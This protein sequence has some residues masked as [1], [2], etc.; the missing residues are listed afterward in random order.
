MS[1]SAQRLNRLLA[2]LAALV[3][4]VGAVL[5]ASRVHTAVMSQDPYMHYLPQARAL[6]N[7]EWS[8]LALRNLFRER[9]PGIPLLLAT[10]IELRDTSWIAW[11]NL[12]FFLLWLG[13]LT[14]L[15]HRWLIDI[16]R[17]TATA[18]L[19]LPALG[20]IGGT[21]AVTTLLLRDNPLAA[22]FLLTPFREM[23]TLAFA[24]TALAL[25]LAPRRL[26]W[27]HALL[28][29]GCLLAATGCREVALAAAPGCLFAC[30]FRGCHPLANPFNESAT[31]WQSHH[32]G[33]QTRFRRTAGVVTAFLFPFVFAIGVLVTLGGLRGLNPQVSGT[34]DKLF[35]PGGGPPGYDLATLLLSQ[36]MWV[37]APLGFLSLW[38]VVRRPALL[39]W[40]G[41]P[42]ALTFLVYRV[43]PG[44]ERYAMAVLAWAL[45]LPVFGALALLGRWKRQWPIAGFAV[46]ALAAF[47]W[48]AAN[49]R[50]WGLKVSS[51]DVTAFREAFETHVPANGPVYYERGTRL[52]SAMVESY[53]HAGHTASPRPDEPVHLLSPLNQAATDAPDLSEHSGMR[54]AQVLL[55]KRDLNPVD[56][57]PLRL[58]DA[59]YQLS[60]ATPWRANAGQQ[61]L[62]KQPHGNGESYILLDARLAEGSGKRTVSM[63]GFG[64]NDWR[65]TW[66]ETGLGLL[67]LPPNAAHQTGHLRWND[68]NAPVPGALLIGR[69]RGDKPIAWGLG[70]TRFG[71]VMQ[72]FDDAWIRGASA[73]K[74]SLRLQPGVPATIVLPPMLNNTPKHWYA[75]FKFRNTKSDPSARLV[76]RTVQTETHPETILSDEPLLTTP[77]INLH[78]N[79]PGPMP[80]LDFRQEGGKGLLLMAMYQHIHPGPQKPGI[81]LPAPSNQD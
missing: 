56:T 38:A 67:Y 6:V 17:A 27:W 44:H 23:P 16:P 70:N 45:P 71:S 18:R 12:P 76:V 11:I 48:T 77:E 54:M 24:F 47:L 69:V 58:G 8:G 79:G 63:S 78:L 2:I 5:A 53:T 75:S 64:T 40:L 26:R 51:A 59:T 49:Q 20:A 7:S 22:N 66:N 32:Q 52:V 60:V 14:A 9:A 10:G 33:R 81:E 39:F 42:A 68:P 31:H 34:L 30:V 25:L 80:P 62:T 28:A 46:L 35:G 57:P 74:Y 55:A 61:T 1:A 37:L 29:G 50:P 73:L 41:L 13:A 3:L 4:T 36:P 65:G 19:P 15:F 21:A 43:H 72:C